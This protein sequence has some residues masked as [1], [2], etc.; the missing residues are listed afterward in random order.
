MLPARGRRASGSGVAGH[1]VGAAAEVV[2]GA[3]EHDDAHRLVRPARVER[4][5]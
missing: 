4:V 3:V 2:A 1:D 5:R